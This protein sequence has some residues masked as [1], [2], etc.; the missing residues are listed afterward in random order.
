MGNLE[1]L[2]SRKFLYLKNYSCLVS[3]SKSARLNFVTVRNA[4]FQQVLCW[5]YLCVSLNFF[6]FLHYQLLDFLVIISFLEKLECFL[7]LFTKSLLRLELS[8][9][10]TVRNMA[11]HCLWAWEVWNPITHARSLLPWSLLQVCITLSKR[12]H[13]Q[14]ESKNTFRTVL[15]F[16]PYKTQV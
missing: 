11:S 4:L 6:Y 7:C 2:F 15:T 10:L 9:Y 14:S 13:L 12:L 16:K 1:N 3:W 8:G 5:W